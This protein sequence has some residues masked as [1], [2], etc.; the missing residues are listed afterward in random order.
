MLEIK[1]V[2]RPHRLY[3]APDLDHLAVEFTLPS[4]DS[5]RALFEAD[6]PSV[7]FFAHL[8]LRGSLRGPLCMVRM[9]GRSHR[10]AV[11]YEA[12]LARRAAAEWPAAADLVLVAAHLIAALDA[13]HAARIRGVWARRRGEHFWRSA[14][15]DDAGECGCR[16]DMAHIASPF[17]V[18]VSKLGP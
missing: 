8:S 3:L 5:L 7:Y 12:T 16:H 14:R 9:R 13:V 17:K 6:K 2:L 18:D 4:F 10:I 11:S 15:Q 1:P